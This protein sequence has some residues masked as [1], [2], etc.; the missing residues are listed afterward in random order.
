LFIFGRNLG[1]VGAVALDCRGNLAYATSTGGIVNKMVGRVGDSPCIGKTE[2]QSYSA[3]PPFPPFCPF[4]HFVPP[5]G[6]SFRIF[7]SGNWVRRGCWVPALR[8]CLHL[9][10]TLFF[11]DSDFWDDMGEGSGDGEF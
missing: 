11:L 9:V 7:G 2:G 10:G 1:T 3:P 8:V 5:L 6:G 4:L